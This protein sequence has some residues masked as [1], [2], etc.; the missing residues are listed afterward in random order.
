MGVS[1]REIAAIYDLSPNTVRLCINKYEKEAGQILL[2]LTVKEAAVLL[3]LRMMQNR[4]LSALPARSLVI[5]DI[6]LNYGLWLHCISISA[7]TRNQPDI[8]G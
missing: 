2:F 5:L 1:I 8:R 7:K 4:G 6:L 3:K